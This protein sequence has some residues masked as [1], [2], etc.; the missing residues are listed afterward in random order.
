MIWTGTL[1]PPPPPPSH[2]IP[3]STLRSNFQPGDTGEAQF[4]NLFFLL[5][6]TVV[7]V[8]VLG[9]HRF[10]RGSWETNRDFGPLDARVFR[11]VPPSPPPLPSPCPS[12]PTCVS[13]HLPPPSFSSPFL[14]PPYPATPPHKRITWVPERAKR[15]SMARGR[16]RRVGRS[17]ELFK[18]TLSRPRNAYTP[19]RHPLSCPPVCGTTPTPYIPFCR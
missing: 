15:G 4:S 18:I 2:T 14:P 10:Q 1:P 8:G 7:Y 3:S 13:L 5:V 9:H 6:G 11:G 16:W 19:L 12:V 17:G